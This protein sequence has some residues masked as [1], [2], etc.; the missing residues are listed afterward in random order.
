M[1]L[2]LSSALGPTKLAVLTASDK[3]EKRRL[4]TY[5]SSVP[6]KPGCSG[7]CSRHLVTTV[8]E[9][10]LVVEHLMANGTWDEVKERAAEI[11]PTARS[12]N[13]LSWFKMNLKCPVLDRKTGL[14]MAWPVRPPACSTHFVTSDPKLC[15]P[16]SGGGA[17]YAALEFDDL[18]DRFQSVLAES[19]VGHGILSLSVVFP[20]G[21]LLAE[22]VR[23]KSGLDMDKVISLIFKE[24]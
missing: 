23:T 19:L 6:C 17:D 4:M 7:C 13:P 21:L 10:L 2:S 11:A 16:W 1:E 8:A 18:Y 14:C 24:T 9:A 5:G 22:K 15:D 20:V 3:A 12:S